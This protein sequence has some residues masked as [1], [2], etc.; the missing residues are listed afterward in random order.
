MSLSE[1][2]AAVIEEQKR[3]QQ[4]EERLFQQGRLLDPHGKVRAT[5]KV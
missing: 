5:C 2:R 3:K 4:R 1:L